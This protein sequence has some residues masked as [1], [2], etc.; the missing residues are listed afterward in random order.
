M[1]PGSVPV[2]PEQWQLQC[3]NCSS[4]PRAQLTPPYNIH[5]LR[6]ALSYVARRLTTPWHYFF[7]SPTIV[8]PAGCHPILTKEAITLTIHRGNG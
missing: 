8:L 1:T 2:P 4:P 6:A 3:P 7:V 5:E